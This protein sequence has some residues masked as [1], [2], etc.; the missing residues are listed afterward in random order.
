MNAI[1]KS[2]IDTVDFKNGVLNIRRMIAKEDKGKMS[3][4]IIEINGENTNV[5]NTL[6]DSIYYITEG[7]GVFIIEREEHRVKAGDCVY[8]PK[9]TVYR[10]KGVM[11]MISICS[12]AYDPDTVKGV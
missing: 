9:G 12:P 7:E 6:S 5:L 1:F 2:I 11:K 3:L 10:D 8:I 4:S